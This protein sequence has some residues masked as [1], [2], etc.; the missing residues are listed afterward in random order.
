MRWDEKLGFSTLFPRSYLFKEMVQDDKVFSDI[1]SELDLEKGI[2]CGLNC[3]S[4]L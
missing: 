3:T 1:C 4:P 2:V